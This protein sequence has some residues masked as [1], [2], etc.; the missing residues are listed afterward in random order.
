MLLLLGTV[1]ATIISCVQNTVDV[2]R[3]LRYGYFLGNLS[4]KACSALLQAKASS[5]FALSAEQQLMKN[6]IKAVP[7]HAKKNI[8]SLLKDVSTS[9]DGSACNS[10][11][12]SAHQVAM[13]KKKQTLRQPVRTK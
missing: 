6:T 2:N 9:S 1:C 5:F 13:I 11:V 7:M 12:R 8:R 4:H 10:Y 3:S